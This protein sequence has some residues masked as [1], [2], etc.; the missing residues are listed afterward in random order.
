M[1]KVHEAGEA[2]LTSGEGRRTERELIKNE[3]VM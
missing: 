2:D 1:I 3:V